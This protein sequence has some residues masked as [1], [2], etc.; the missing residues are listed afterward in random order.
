MI[1]ETISATSQTSAEVSANKL[2]RATMEGTQQKLSVQVKP[3]S[4]AAFE[5]VLEGGINADNGQV[6]DWVEIGSWTE[7]DTL[8]STFDA[9]A[10]TMLRMRHVSGIPCRVVVTG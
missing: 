3:N 9:S 2:Y 5:V 8:L 7:T 10:R 6:V 1:D 4:A